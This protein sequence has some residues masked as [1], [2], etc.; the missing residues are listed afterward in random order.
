MK[1]KD[2]NGVTLRDGDYILSTGDGIGAFTPK[3]W[4]AGVFRQPSEDGYCVEPL[5]KLTDGSYTVHLPILEYCTYKIDKATAWA[6]VNRAA[7]TNS[8]YERALRKHCI[9]QHQH[10][11]HGNK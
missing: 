2:S 5:V 9:D 7:L 4:T 11:T 6:V 3:D 8:I 10:C 1:F